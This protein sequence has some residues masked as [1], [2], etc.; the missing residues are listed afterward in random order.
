MFNEMDYPE[1]CSRCRTRFT[2]TVIIDPVIGFQPKERPICPDCAVALEQ[3]R[4]V[5]EAKAREA[6]IMKAEAEALSPFKKTPLQCGV[7]PTEYVKMFEALAGR[8]PAC[9]RECSPVRFMRAVGEDPMHP[10]LVIDHDHAMEAKLAKGEM[11]RAVRGLLCDP[12]NKALGLMRDDPEA[13]DGL[14]NYAKFHANGPKCR[15]L[16]ESR[17]KPQ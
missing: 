1:T 2:E 4:L 9:K 15:V 16:I 3:A 17:A 6:E 8:C 7:T 5:V 10:L 14:L 12:C 11:W 13:I